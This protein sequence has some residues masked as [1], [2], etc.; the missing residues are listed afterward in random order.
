MTTFVQDKSIILDAPTTVRRNMTV[1]GIISGQITSSNIQVCGTPVSGVTTPCVS[2]TA[3]K[4]G[5]ANPQLVFGNDINVATGATMF[6][7][8]KKITTDS[9]GSNLIL[10]DE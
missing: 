9:T 6:Y 1:E 8:G 3:Q 10:S 4:I 5:A 2:I 7:R